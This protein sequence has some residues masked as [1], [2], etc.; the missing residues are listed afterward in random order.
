M[1]RKEFYRNQ[2]SIG[3][4]DPESL[5]YRNGDKMILVDQDQFIEV[6]SDPE[7]FHLVKIPPDKEK[8]LFDA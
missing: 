4:I 2:F 8:F 6:D 3:D 7:N 1:A 5:W